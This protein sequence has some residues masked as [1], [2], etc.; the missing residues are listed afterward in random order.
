V[1]IASSPPLPV[2]SV[3]AALAM[4][5]RVPWILDVRDPWPEV[6]VTLGE[7][8]DGPL[9]RAA[10]WLE[11]RLYRSAAAITTSTK[12]HQDLIEERGGAGK[13][14]VIYN[15]AT[16]MFLAAGERDP[17]PEL[18]DD[19]DGTFVWT[20]AGNLGLAQGLESAVEAAGILGDGFRLI[21]IGDGP[22]RE[23]LREL[24]RGL[25]AG[26]AEVR[27]AIP[28][29]DVA[30][31]TR[32][33][34]ALLVALAPTPGLEGFVPSK[35]FDCCAVGRPVILAAVGESVRLTEEAGAA[36]SVPPGDAGALAG[37]VRK[38]RDD[39]KLS[40]ELA[41]RGREFAE[42]NAREVGVETLDRLV[43]SIASAPK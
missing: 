4:R 37:A 31:L 15:G 33:S 38:L 12:P 2:G 41:T 14:T 23:H 35:L 39:G 32:A 21:L 9:L 22:R 20:Y 29:A 28:P 34:D 40:T 25:P 16:P 5:H 27:D 10:E 7:V 11:R 13:V 24:A 6:A 19:D 30:R 18:V 36:I 3:G 17:E 8:E 43:T 26:Q 1:I 42:R